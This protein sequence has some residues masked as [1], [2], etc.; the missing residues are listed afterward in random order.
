MQFFQQCSRKNVMDRSENTQ[1]EE[2]FGLI[3]TGTQNER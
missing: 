2:S 1:T 3:Q